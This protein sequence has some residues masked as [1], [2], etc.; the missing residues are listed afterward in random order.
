MKRELEVNFI[1]YA[2]MSR[3]ALPVMKPREWKD[4]QRGIGRRNYRISRT[5][6]PGR[7]CRARL[8]DPARLRGEAHR[9]V[10]RARGGEF[11]FDCG[12]LATGQSVASDCQHKSLTAS[13]VECQN[14]QCSGARHERRLGA[15]HGPTQRLRALC[16]PAYSPEATRWAHHIEDRRLC[17]DPKLRIGWSAVVKGLAEEVT[18]HLGRTAEHIRK[19]PVHPVAP[20]ERRHWLA[21]RPAE[22]SG[23]RFQVRAGPQRRAH[24]WRRPP[25]GDYRR[26]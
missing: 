21:I 4:P 14:I 23:R 25:P 24:D 12:H 3:A 7:A 15:H 18:G 26:A 1:A 17:R 20:G 9:S 19:G 2:R 10:E 6:R 11:A 5:I 16:C 22:V 13:P 8:H